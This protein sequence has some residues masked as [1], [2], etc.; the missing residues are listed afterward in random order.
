VGFLKSRRKQTKI[1]KSA[2]GESCTLRIPGVCNHNPE[3]VVL[4][5]AGRGGGKRLMDWWACYGC[6]DCHDWMDGRASRNMHEMHRDRYV[7]DAVRETQEK[8]I[9]KGLI[10]IP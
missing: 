6:A 5:H 9:K 1:T 2:R 4:C 3:T 10:V 7:A 8:L